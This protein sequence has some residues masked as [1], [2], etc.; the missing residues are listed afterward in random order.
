VA[1]YGLFADPS[2]ISKHL[3][4]LSGVLPGA[5]DV[6][7]DQLQRLSHHPAHRAPKG[8]VEPRWRTR[9]EKEAI[10]APPLTSSRIGSNTTIRTPARVRLG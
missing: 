8:R 3:T 4:D 7:G 5:T 1:L 9:L 6:I 2:T 10:D